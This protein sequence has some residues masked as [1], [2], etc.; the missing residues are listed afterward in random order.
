MYLIG[1][2]PLATAAVILT[3]LVAGGGVVGLGLWVLRG[4]RMN[5]A[6][7]PAQHY[8]DEAEHPSPD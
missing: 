8:P 3:F 2:W 4:D 1:E 5:H 6:P 7:E